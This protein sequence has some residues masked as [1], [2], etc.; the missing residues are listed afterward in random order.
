MIPTLAINPFLGVA[1][2]AVLQTSVLIG[3]IL[4]V[5]DRFHRAQVAEKSRTR[6][7]WSF[8]ED[9][10]AGIFV[11]FGVV[12]LY[13]S[14]LWCAGAWTYADWRYQLPSVILQGVIGVLYLLRTLRSKQ[15]RWRLVFAAFTAASLVILLQGVISTLAIMGPLLETY[16]PVLLGA[17]LCVVFIIGAVRAFQHSKRLRPDIKA[18]EIRT[19]PKISKIFSLPVNFTL[20]VLAVGQTMFLF[21]GYSWFSLG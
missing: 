18:E 15:H 16:L 4:N 14:I 17:L 10:G 5:P 13:I 2:A 1:I 8:L 12:F 6:I 3:Y 20:W 19:V 21:L 9:A 7:L 11:L